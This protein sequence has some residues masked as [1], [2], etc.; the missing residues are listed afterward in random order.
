[1]SFEVVLCHRELECERWDLFLFR[2]RK[3]WVEP[4]TRRELHAP[5]F[6]HFLHV[7]CHF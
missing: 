7:A 6:S 5:S 3:C 4:L 2:F 1:M